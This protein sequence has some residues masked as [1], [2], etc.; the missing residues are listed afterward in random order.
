[1]LLVVLGAYLIGSIPFG[2][3][4]A[5][6]A[7]V[8]LQQTGSGNIGATNVLRTLGKRAGALVFFLD[9]LKG[10]LPVWAT[11]L[12]T[13]DLW[14]SSLVG[15][16]AIV[17]HIFPVWL[18]FKGGKGVATTAGVMLPLSPDLFVV[19]L[20]FFILIVFVTRMVSLGSIGIGVL[21][22]ILMFLM[23]K[24]LPV[25]LLMLIAAILITYKH[26]PNLQRIMQGTE[27]R[28]GQGDK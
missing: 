2:V 28:L 15:L 23:Q 17:G 10:S 8:N 7:N 24:P 12:L 16:L 22:T 25:S 27:P 13:N 9:F 14:L 1:M 5:K 11:L 19:G 4:V 20:L 21:I 26:F 18:G 6:F 3:L